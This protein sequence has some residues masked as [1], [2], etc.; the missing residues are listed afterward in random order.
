MKEKEV[1]FYY[2]VFFSKKEAVLCI[3]YSV[4][5]TRRMNSYQGNH[6][7]ETRVGFDETPIKI[8]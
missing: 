1:T 5:G 2:Q 4:I 3:K 6:I 7:K 8:L